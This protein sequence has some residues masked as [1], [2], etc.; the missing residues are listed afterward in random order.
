MR[1]VVVEQVLA[2]LL[3]LAIIGHRELYTWLGKALALKALLKHRRCLEWLC[4][5]IPK[6]LSRHFNKIKA[7]ELLCQPRRTPQKSQL[8]GQHLDAS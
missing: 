6:N 7:R 8:R 4:E 5:R 2:T 3:L 1:Q